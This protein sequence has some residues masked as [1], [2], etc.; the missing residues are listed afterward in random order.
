MNCKELHF[1]RLPQ[2][3]VRNMK[4]LTPLTNL[5][6]VVICVSKFLCLRYL[7]GFPCVT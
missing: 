1:L 6:G 4:V 3:Y 5:N 7:V 2:G